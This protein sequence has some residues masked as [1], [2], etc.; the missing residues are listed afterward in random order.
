MQK[1]NSHTYQHL[2]VQWTNRTTTKLM[3]SLWNTDERI[4]R[5]GAT[6]ATTMAI[7]Q[8]EIKKK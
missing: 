4:N 2:Q 5:V 6:A 3:H 7:Q 8:R 1:S